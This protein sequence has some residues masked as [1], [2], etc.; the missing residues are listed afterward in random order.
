MSRDLLN[1]GAGKGDKSRV[2]FGQNWLDRFNEIAGLQPKDRAGFVKTKRGW[3]K[4]YG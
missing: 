2:K 3:V 1:H 4:R